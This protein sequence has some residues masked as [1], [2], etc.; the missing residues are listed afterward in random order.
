VL[1]VFFKSGT[2]AKGELYPPQ[3]GNAHF[4]QGAN[5]NSRMIETSNE[6]WIN[7]IY[8][9]MQ[10]T[11]RTLRKRVSFPSH[12]SRVKLTIV[13]DL[14]ENWDEEKLRTVVNQNEQKQ[15]NATDVCD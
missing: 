7:S 10:E 9:R 6:R 8:T 5:V 14:M 4:P 12:Q 1:C 13:I 15:K 3:L 2:C 11:R